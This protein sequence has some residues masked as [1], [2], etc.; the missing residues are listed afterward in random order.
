[1]GLALDKYTS[2]GKWFEAGTELLLTLVGIALIVRGSPQVR[3]MAGGALGLLGL[4]VGLSVFQVFRHGLV[5]SGLP[6][7]LVRLAAVISISAGA[8]ATVVGLLVFKAE[9][10]PFP[11]A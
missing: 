6:S 10:R 9:P 5:L 1:V 2:S 3:T 11:S 7:T 8:V 4:A